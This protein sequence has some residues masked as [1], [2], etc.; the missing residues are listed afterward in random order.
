MDY[1]RNIDKV[2][3]CT[4]GVSYNQV[5]DVQVALAVSAELF[6]AG[7]FKSEYA[8]IDTSEENA[9]INTLITT[10]R[11]MCE[12][13]VGIS[14]VAR[15]VV[16]T[17]NNFNGGAYLPYGPIGTIS[18]VT[19]IDG[20]AI[21]ATSY[22]LMGSEFKKVLWPLA[23]LIFT[24]TGGYTAGNCPA[25]LINAVKAQTLFLFEHRGDESVGMSPIATMILNPLRRS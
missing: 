3:T 8:K 5:Y 14:F 23:E 22:K 9:L 11:Q 18:S 16:A 17:I 24:Y 21:V 15:T 13:Y 10:A 2:D 1:N 12:Q 4:Q 19:D 20:N 6:D 25:N 7:T